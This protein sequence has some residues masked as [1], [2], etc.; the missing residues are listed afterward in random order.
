MADSSTDRPARGR[1]AAA[2][3]YEAAAE[4]AA[5]FDPRRDWEPADGPAAGRRGFLALAAAAGAV[6]AGGAV[7]LRPLR[8]STQA[9]VSFKMDEINAV[10]Y[11]ATHFIGRNLPQTIDWQMVRVGSVG[12]ARVAAFTRGDLDGFATGWNYLAT[13]ELKGLRGVAVSGVGGGGSR[14]VARRG[15]GITKLADVKGRRV[16]VLQLNSQ[17]IML[18]YALKAIGIDAMKE[19]NRVAIGNPGGVVAALARGDIDAA[20]IQEPFGSV[21]MAQQ[22]ATMI[23]DYNQEAFGPSHGGLYIRED[24]VRQQPAATEAIVGAVVKA[25]E[26]L[27]GDKEAY[28]QFAMRVTGQTREIATLSVNNSRQSPLMP[29]DTIRKICRAVHELGLEERDVSGII[30]NRVNYSFLEKVTGRPKEQLGYVA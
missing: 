30:Q 15:S 13:I 17:D 20:S 3:L 22:G 6:L 10:H 8:T 23:T 28:I 11:L 19:V 1:D 12:H 25:I 2:A 27:N 26:Y 16:G 18:I 5:A 14:L 29:M 21:M 4:R 24:F 9:R 7:G